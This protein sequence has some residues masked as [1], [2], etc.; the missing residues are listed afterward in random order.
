MSWFYNM[1]DII[2]FGAK[3]Y[4]DNIAF[5]YKI[6]K[7]EI[8]EKSYK[9]LRRDSEGFS[10][11]LANI[12]MTGKHIAL[13]G[14]TSYKWI[15]CYF[16]IVNSNSV[17]VPLD[18]LLPVADLCE[19]IER[20][21]AEVVIYD[22]G[23]ED[24]VNEIKN[25]N[26]KVKYIISMKN[27]E[28]ANG[29]YSLDKLM[30]KYMNSYSTKID[31]EKM[32]SIQFTSGTT[33]KSKGVMLNHRNLT[34]NAIFT[35]MKIKPGTVSLTVLPIHH[36]FCFTMDIL[37]GLSLGLCICINDSIIR[38]NKNMKLF[39][40][41]VMCL[42]PMII[43]SMYDKLVEA[44]GIK[45]KK[46]V[47]KLAF[48]GNLKNIYS[49]GAYLNPKYIEGFEKYGITV[50]QGYGMTECSPVISTNYPQERKDNSV[51]RLLANCEVKIVDNEILVKGSSVMLG[52]YKMEKETR[53]VLEDGWLKTGD[54]GYVDDD[55]FVFVTGRKK[56]LIILSNGEN[57]S[58]EEIENSLSENKIVQE[59]LVSSRENVIT[60][61]V[62]P[63]LEYIEKK[64][65]KDISGEIQRV[66]DEYNYRVPSYKNIN[67]LIVREKEFE[68]TTSK[69]IKRTS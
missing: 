59:V 68:K 23:R 60:A 6:S 2:N 28:D 14:S 12:G 58:P 38:L 40:P 10:S 56:N 22:N 32:C 13:V 18:A 51:G 67:R 50:L 27:E 69:K 35:E 16:G 4:G 57:V 24:L 15:Y 47:A 7:N 55:G 42:V 9:D 64:N 1:K 41:E 46:I 29:I 49:G 31:N 44:T 54:L 8:E 53:E 25:R 3:E 62:Y 33:G 17:V 66:V 52:Y 65:I 5:K 26:K 37:K 21:D 11:V 45:P 39:K 36:S 63:R 61:E 43:E 20:S 34:E 48:G 19:L 30:S